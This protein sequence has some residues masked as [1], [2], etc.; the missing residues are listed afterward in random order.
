MKIMLRALA[1]LTMLAAPLAAA[2]AHAVSMMRLSVSGTFE[3]FDGPSVASRFTGRAM[4]FDGL[5]DQEAVTEVF[6]ELRHPLTSLTVTAGG[7]TREFETPTMF[8]LN[9]GDLLAGIVSVD[10]QFGL[11]RFDLDG[12]NSFYTDDL[13]AAFAVTGGALQL[14]GASAIRYTIAAVPEPAT[15]ALSIGGFLLVGWTLRRRP[16]AA[17]LPAG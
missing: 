6:G 12:R 17:I 8:F 4:T 1:V 15:W 7:V 2:P 9:P 3:G 14:T 16:S 5:F 11:L 10:G 13:T